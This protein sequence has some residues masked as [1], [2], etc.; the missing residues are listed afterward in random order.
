MTTE[1]MI[2]TVI[3]DGVRAYRKNYRNC[4]EGIRL[5]MHQPVERYG[6]TF[7]CWREY[8]V[9]KMAQYILEE[10]PGIEAE[11]VLDGN[12]SSL[13]ISLD[14]EQQKELNSKLYNFIKKVGL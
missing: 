14:D 7:T 1:D 2:E 3:E 4:P 10:C 11:V 12:N 8:T 5:Q 9:Y 6:V 13:Q